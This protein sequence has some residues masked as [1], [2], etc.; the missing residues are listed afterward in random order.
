MNRA[1]KAMETKAATALFMSAHGIVQ[2]KPVLVVARRFV[3]HSV[4]EAGTKIPVAC[5]ALGL[6]YRR[7]NLAL[8]PTGIHNRK[9]RA[10]LGNPG[11]LPVVAAFIEANGKPFGAWLVENADDIATVTTAILDPE[12]EPRSRKSSLVWRSVLGGSDWR[13]VLDALKLHV[14][15]YKGKVTA[16]DLCELT[17][18]RYVIFVRALH[19]T[20]KGQNGKDPGHLATLASVCDMEPSDLA[21]WYRSGCPAPARSFAEVWE[22]FLA[23]MEKKKIL[24]RVEQKP[25]K[26]GIQAKEA[27]KRIHG[28]CCAVCGF[29]FG[30]FY[31]DIGAGFIQVHH[32]TM[33]AERRDT[34]NPV[35]DMVPLCSNC[36][37]MMHHGLSDPAAVRQLK[38]IVEE[39]KQANSRAGID[40][41][42]EI[43]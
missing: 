20:G 2:W 32:L 42:S 30:L 3:F 29:D 21:A 4:E 31:G 7:L 9:E 12:W 18:V 41:R 33:Q 13:E 40:P 36:H 43:D 17:G 34:V 35:T 23:D 19:S 38:V 28:T 5:E 39:Q 14:R 6:E 1:Q 11:D 15:A 27:A 25:Y 8:Y 24:A 22:P 26:D 37:D 10:C 16:R